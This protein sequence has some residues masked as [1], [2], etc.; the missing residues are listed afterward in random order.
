MNIL[1][2]NRILYYK[3][4]Y[5]R[6]VDHHK[7]QGRAQYTWIGSSHNPKNAG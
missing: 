6:G 2:L 5:A 3:V 7:H 4:E 1:I